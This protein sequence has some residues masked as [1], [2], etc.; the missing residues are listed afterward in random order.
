M[1]KKMHFLEIEKAGFWLVLA[2]IIGV[3]GLFWRHQL[4]ITDGQLGVPLDDAWIHYQFARNIGQGNG[5][6]F[7]PNQPT[8]GSTAPLW[9]IILAGVG[10]FSEAYLGP[11]ILLSVLFLLLTI[12]MVYIVMRRWGFPVPVALLAMI[13]GG[14]SGRLLWAGLS[15]MEVTLF[16]FLSLFAI[17]LY[18]QKGFS[19]QTAVILGLASQVRP[20]GH[21]L[22]VI[23]FSDTL[24]QNFDLKNNTPRALLSALFSLLIIPTAVYT[25]IN[26]PYTLFAL[27]VTGRPL[28]NTFYAKSD[29]SQLFSWRTLQELTRIHFQDNAFLFLMVPFGC[30]SLWQRSRVSLLWLGGLFFIT[31]MVVPLLWHHGRYTMPLIPFMMIVGAIGSWTLFQQLEKMKAGR[32]W[33]TAVALLVIF[34]SGIRLPFWATMLG[35][36][37]REIIEIDVAMG[38]WFAE[39]SAPDSLIA[40]DDIGAIGFL[41]EREIFDLNGLIS[42]KFG[43]L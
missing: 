18:H 1:N 17:Y 43:P 3:L 41:S 19:W 38:N 12:G 27:S 34:S 21:L 39:N 14:L 15:G 11:S 10:L 20:E 24:I 16:S 26:L 35:N 5:F 23:L 29:S 4:Q 8:P 40:V 32:I 30:W 2:I 37:S 25:L 9:T 7:N 42:P 22:F 13:G 36:N 31:P 28:P 33:A 6:S